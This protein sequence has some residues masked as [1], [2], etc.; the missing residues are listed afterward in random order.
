MSS[1]ANSKKTEEWDYYTSN[2]FDPAIFKDH[3]VLM[4]DDDM[5]YA[6]LLTVMLKDHVTHSRYLQDGL[7]VINYLK[8]IEKQKVFIFLDLNMPAATG[9]EVIEYVL[10]RKDREYIQIAVMSSVDK[11]FFYQNPLANHVHYFVSKPFSKLSLLR[12]LTCL[13]HMEKNCS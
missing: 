2:L 3:Q 5:I 13:K 6:Q 7:E 1:G 12:S 8:T 10:S 11:R 4:V 9:Y